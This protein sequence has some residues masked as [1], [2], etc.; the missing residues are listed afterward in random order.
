MSEEDVKK[1]AARGGNGEEKPAD[2]SI[3]DEDARRKEQEELISKLQDEIDK[4]S[5]KDVVMQM[6]MSLSS[7]AY[8]KM[9]I[10]EGVN[11]KYKDRAQA[12]LAVDCFEALLK[13]L[14]DEV[15]A[16]ENENL[17][18]SLTNLQLNFV[19]KFI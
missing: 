12:K 7:L 9:G 16:Q 1:K 17:K 6:M 2:D 11:D 3:A 14:A 5:T 4:L 19:K 10:P 18:A 15:S 13:I 8:K